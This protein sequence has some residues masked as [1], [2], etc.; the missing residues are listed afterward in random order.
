MHDHEPR[1][2]Q[3][4]QVMAYSPRRLLE[5]LGDLTDRRSGSSFDGEEDPPEKRIPQNSEHCLQLIR[6]EA[7]FRLVPRILRRLS[8]AFRSHS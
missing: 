8:W 7:S 4:G 6:V 1:F 3:A 2:N 5:P